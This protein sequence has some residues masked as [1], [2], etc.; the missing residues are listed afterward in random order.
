MTRRR[1]TSG[2]TCMK[3]I[4]NCLNIELKTL[5]YE[6]RLYYGAIR[7]NRIEDFTDQL[8]KIHRH[9]V[10]CAA[11]SVQAAAVAQR[12]LQAMA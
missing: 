11:E 3:H 9:A 8:N 12:A 7:N 6:L 2:K 10:F 5:C 1:R 4:P